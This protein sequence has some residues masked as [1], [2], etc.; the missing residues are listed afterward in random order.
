MFVTPRFGVCSALVPT[1]AAATSTATATT[2]GH[3]PLSV[4]RCVMFISFDSV[5]VRC[6]WSVFRRAQDWSPRRA[7]CRSRDFPLALSDERK[8]VAVDEIGMRGGET[9]RQAW[10]VDFD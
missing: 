10:I 1:A 2:A 6:L 8:Q 4:F 7:G 5:A 3:R 9:V